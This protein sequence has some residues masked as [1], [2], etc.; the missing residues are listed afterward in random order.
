MWGEGPPPDGDRLLRALALLRRVS[1]VAVRPR[2]P[3]PLAATAWVSWA[4]GRS[5]H[6]AGYAAKA[7]RIDSDHGLAQIVAAMVAAGHLPDW[8]FT[9]RST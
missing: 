8:A 2:K 6:A 9:A 3:G 1:A 7:L 5:T 4:L